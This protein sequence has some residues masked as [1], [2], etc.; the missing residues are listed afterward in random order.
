[1]ASKKLVIVESPAK[2]KTINKILGKD[3]KVAA[4]IGHI[5]D[6]PKAKLG[7]D[8][9]D[10]FKP[11][12]VTIKGK[13][14]IIRELK[15]EAEKVEEILIATDPDREGEAIAFHIANAIDSKKK[16]ISRI[17]FN[18]ITADA[19]LNATDCTRPALNPRKMVCQRNGLT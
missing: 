16:R 13:N 17:E 14:K 7:V 5:I 8:I 3:Y 18:E 1:M 11:E 4:S 15:S 12:Y 2:A 9:E 6:L 10:H 19:V